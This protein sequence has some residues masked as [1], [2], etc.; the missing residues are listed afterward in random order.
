MSE[1]EGEKVAEI[2]IPKDSRVA[3]VVVDTQHTQQLTAQNSMLNKELEQKSEEIDDLKNKLAIIAEKELEKR[4]GFVESKINATFKDT[5]KRTE[6]IE[7]LKTLPAEQLKSFEG[8]LDAFGSVAP[9]GQPK[10]ET[11]SGQAPIN[12]DYNPAQNTDIYKQKFG[13]YD[14]MIKALRTESKST[15]KE[16]AQKATVILN[17]LLN[18]YARA[19]KFQHSELRFSEDDNIAKTDKVPTID[20]SEST[21]TFS[22]L[23][24]FGIKKSP[25]NYSK[26]PITA[27]KDGES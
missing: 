7:Q 3:Q 13:S 6:L 9:K 11:P 26:R 17:E 22:E 19:Q 1:N 16:K 23:E 21:E 10:A 12:P 15:D 2:K 24:R 18:R 25:L 5:G 27:K 4:K 14:D 20:F 8:M